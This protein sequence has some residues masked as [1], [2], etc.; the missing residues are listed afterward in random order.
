MPLVTMPPG[1]LI[2]N[3]ISVPGLSASSSKNLLMIS[4]A[5]RSS[6]GSP[7]L[8]GT[9]FKEI[10]LQFFHQHTRICLRFL[11]SFFFG[12]LHHPDGNSLTGYLACFMVLFLEYI[13]FSFFSF[14]GLITSTSSTRPYSFAS[15][16]CQPVI[17]IR[18]FFNLL[19]SFSCMKCINII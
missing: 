7:Q 13:K 1:L 17:T 5:E 8:N 11:S 14:L 12:R 19:G 3:L 15:I 16:G 2:R 6:T 18:I 4:F 10:F 9:G